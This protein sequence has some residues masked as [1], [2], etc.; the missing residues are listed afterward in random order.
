VWFLFHTAWIYAFYE[1]KKE[2]RNPVEENATFVLMR[3]KELDIS[4]SK[5]NPITITN[6]E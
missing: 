6:L 5:C 3:W 4:S 2:K 1:D